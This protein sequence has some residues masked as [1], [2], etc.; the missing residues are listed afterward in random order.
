[1][2]YEEFTE[3]LSLEQRCAFIDIYFEMWNAS[4]DNCIEMLDVFKR[5]DRMNTSIGED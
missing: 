5:L 1:M 2:N 3:S 4:I